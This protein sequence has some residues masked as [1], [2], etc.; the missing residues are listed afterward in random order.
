MESPTIGV[1][2]V[3]RKRDDGEIGGTGP[4]PGMGPWDRLGRVLAGR[5]LEGSV[6]AHP[7]LVPVEVDANGDGHIYEVEVLNGDGYLEEAG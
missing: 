6:E 2:I 3:D 5:Q 4:C 1:G 7:E